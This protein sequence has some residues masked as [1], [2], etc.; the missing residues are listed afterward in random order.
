MGV[1]NIS[2]IGKTSLNDSY[3]VDTNIWIYQVYYANKGIDDLGN[4]KMKKLSNYSDF[5]QR[6]KQDGGKLYTSPLCLSELG[7]FIEKQAYNHYKETNSQSSITLKSFRAISDKRQI[8]VKDIQQAWEDIIYLAEIL[9]LNTNQQTGSDLIAAME[10][11]PLDAYD[12]IFYLTMK[13]HNIRNIIS[14][15]RDFH[16]ISS[17]DIYTS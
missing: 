3:F 12:S 9:E 5:L 8:I 14:D 4:D 17:I 16:P 1:M 6:V 15:D 13:Q 7:H 11:Y 2:Q 10:D